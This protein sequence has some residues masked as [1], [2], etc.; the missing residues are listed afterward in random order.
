MHW[1]QSWH[2]LEVSC[3]PANRSLQAVIVCTEWAKAKIGQTVPKFLCLFS[4]KLGGIVFSRR[5]LE[6]YCVLDWYEGELFFYSVCCLREE[7][8]T[9][10][11]DGGQWQHLLWE[12]GGWRAPS[13]APTSRVS[14]LWKPPP[15]ALKM[16][17]AS[18]GKKK[19]TR[20]CP[21]VNTGS[22]AFTLLF[23]LCSFFCPPAPCD[24]PSSTGSWKFVL[25]FQTRQRLS[26]IFFFFGHLRTRK[27]WPFIHQ[28]LKLCLW[29]KALW[30]KWSHN[31]T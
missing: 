24:L 28:H 23:H 20:Q 13:R 21:A 11:K 16:F 14:A 22:G 10:T 2:T 29:N 18:K 27:Y 12:T 25:Q 4:R 5:A 19:G 17:A 1:E 7:T 30:H 31:D 26:L 9:G 3:A 8:G 6:V 15:L